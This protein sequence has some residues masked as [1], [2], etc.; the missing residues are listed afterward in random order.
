[1][2]VS[3]KVIIQPLT[4]N[5]IYGA[6]IDVTDQVRETGVSKIKQGIDSTDYDFGVFL[7]DDL[8]IKVA[9]SNGKFN[10]AFDSRSIFIAGRDRAK[11]KIIYRNFDKDTDGFYQETDTI[12]FLGMINEEATREN[13]ASE[14]VNLKVLSRDSVIRNTKVASGAI[15]AGVT[16]KSAIE[17]IINTPR[18]TSILTF[19]AAN[20]NPDLNIVLDVGSVYD[21]ESTR[22]VLTDLLRISNSV[23]I[24][25][26]SDNMIVKSRAEDTT[27]DILNLFGKS[28]ELGRENIKSISQYN[29]GLH[30]MFNSVKVNGV[31]KSDTAIAAGFGERTKELTFESITDPVK[32]TDIATRL[33]N[34]FKAPKI[35][36]LL[37]VPT[38]VAKNVELLDRV[39]VNF[40]LRVHRPSP[41][42]FLPVIGVATIGDTET[43]LPAVT[44]SR[45]IMPEIAF[46]VIEIAENPKLFK[47]TLKLRQK[48]TGLSD[49]Q[50]NEAGNCI[51]GF[52]VIGECILTAGDD[53]ATF[54]SSPLGGAIIGKTKLA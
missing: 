50:F 32:S 9:N 48:G 18:I 20:I 5:N 25:D 45:A 51:L 47:T 46:K 11:V 27:R 38:E 31:E 35:E 36:L 39:S 49:G 12:T 53:D 23:M 41:G 52:A 1:M 40:P 34:E 14:T 3:Y 2:P 4:A 44:G 7:Y 10:D 43:P 30:R 6:E 19:S 26:D 28:D 21:N 42:N 24:I 16:V 8:T 13:F 29:S 37:D 33:L 22:T 15:A 54:F 17:T